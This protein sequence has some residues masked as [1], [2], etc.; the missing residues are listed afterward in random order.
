MQ[1]EV[2]SLCDAATA[3]NG[4]LNMLGAFD[5]IF[6]PKIPLVYPH[7]AVAARIR[8][9]HDE[10]GEHQITVNIVNVDG[11]HLLPTMNGRLSVNFPPEHRSVSLNLIF[12][13]QMLKFET[14]GEHSIDLAVD[15]ERRVSL[16]LFVRERK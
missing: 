5:T 9:A 15:G 11:K 2:F 6:V 8:F 10:Q 13:I 7:C 14:L 3:D 16:P 4:K 1:I 12:N